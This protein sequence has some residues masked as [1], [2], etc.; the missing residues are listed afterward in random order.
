MSNTIVVSDLE[1]LSLDKIIAANNN[2]SENKYII[3]GDVID[4]TMIN[5]TPDLTD[6]KSF[7]IQNI[8][9]IATNN[10]ISLALGN[11]DLN[12]IK[13]ILLGQLKT[14]GGNSTHDNY[15]DQFNK[16]TLDFNEYDNFSGLLYPISWDI[17]IEE[18]PLFWSKILNYTEIEEKNK[19]FASTRINFFYNRFIDVFQIS[20]GAGHLL[21]TI[22]VELHRGKILENTIV[23]DKKAF[24]V[25]LVFNRMLNTK[26]TTNILGGAITSSLNT[27]LV[28]SLD[29]LNGIL[30]K[31][32]QKSS[33]CFSE[34]IGEK[35]YIFSHGGIQLEMLDGINYNFQNILL[36]VGF[37][38]SDL[39]E[40][41]PEETDIISYYQRQVQKINKYYEL[42]ITKLLALLKNYSADKKN[43]KKLIDSAD[44]KNIKKLIDFLLTLCAPVKCTEITTGANSVCQNNTSMDTEKISPIIPGLQNMRK[45]YRNATKSSTKV[46]HNYITLVF[47]HHPFGYGGFADIFG[48][49]IFV[50]LDTSNSFNSTNKSTELTTNP[51]LIIP[52][53]GT[54]PSIKSTVVFSNSAKIYSNSRKNFKDLK[55]SA[56][57]IDNFNAWVVDNFVEDETRVFPLTID[58]KFD[59]TEHYDK[60]TDI[61]K[62]TSDNKYFFINLH[63]FQ[64]GYY[65]FTVSF[66]GTYD[67]I[68]GLL[69]YKFNVSFNN[70]FCI[71]SEKDFNKFIR[72]PSSELIGGSA[73]YKNKYLKYKKKYLLLKNF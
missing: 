45:S 56:D 14:V 46:V 64:E 52:H 17:D 19:L 2:S 41:L 5:K 3:C 13:L 21:D 33:I 73:N 53:N 16:G 54:I 66:T 1:G 36:N 40:L 39:T 65:Y 68:D 61:Q 63:S 38:H 37:S 22:L 28:T 4:S 69:K 34:V 25:F 51:Q 24:I 8:L 30:I 29:S 31:L 67:D 42:A 32:Y 70:I 18:F 49:I 10:K 26:T 6:A 62:S 35:L 43:I 60:L 20:M 58:I 57:N 15:I 23:N 7:N 71:F 27:S 48:K 12:K 44:K 72:E 55:L 59:Y 50:G 47:G 9:T 11:R